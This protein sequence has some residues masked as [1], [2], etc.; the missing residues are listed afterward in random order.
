MVGRCTRREQR[1]SFLAPLESPAART[2]SK[3]EGSQAPGER[4]AFNPQPVHQ[5]LLG[6]H[7]HKCIIRQSIFKFYDNLCIFVNFAVFG[8]LLG[9]K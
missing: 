7:M 8:D 4:W 1:H 6:L 3:G 9:H 2:G 5:P